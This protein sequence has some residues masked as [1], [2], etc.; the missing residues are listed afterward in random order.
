MYSRRIL[1]VVETIRLRNHATHQ[2]AVN[3]L[4]PRTRTFTT[5][6][7]YAQGLPPGS[8]W[9]ETPGFDPVKLQKTKPLLTSNQIFKTLTHKYTICI[10]VIIIGGATVFYIQ[11]LETAP[12]SGRRRFMYFTEADAEEMYKYVY[13]YF[14]LSLQQFILPPWDRR[15]KQVNRVMKRLIESCELEHVDWE[16]NVVLSSEANAFV[17]PGGKVF[18]MSGILSIADTDAGLASVLSHE[19]AHGLANHHAE[20]M[21][22][23]FLVTWPLRIA[24]FL[25]FDI[26]TG[27][28]F[29]NLLLEYGFNR[30][31]SR[32]HEREADYIGLMMMS[33]ACYDPRAAFVFM[34]RLEQLEAAQGKLD[35]PWLSTHPSTASRAELIQNWLPK[36]FEIRAKT[37]CSKYKRFS[38]RLNLNLRLD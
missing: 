5:T 7:K 31:A 34:K 37:D 24:I 11:H 3:L 26:I 10:Y 23:A 22:N 20:N 38:D 9:N 19:I 12:V 28:V 4:L 21:S 16:V 27:G 36:A 35:I 17:L 33:R 13:R 8:S 2:A 6:P 32:T 18:V 15:T 14:K 1:K 25:L 29:G 30:P